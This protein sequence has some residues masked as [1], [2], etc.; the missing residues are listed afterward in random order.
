MLKTRFCREF[1]H[2]KTNRRDKYPIEGDAVLLR[3]FHRLKELKK[4]RIT[5][6]KHANKRERSQMSLIFNNSPP[7]SNEIKKNPRKTAVCYVR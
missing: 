7:G 3:V 2:K 1:G 5:A 4:G 6:E